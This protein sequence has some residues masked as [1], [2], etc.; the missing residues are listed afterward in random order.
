MVAD[1]A[2][3]R[4]KLAANAERFRTGMTKLGFTLAAPAIRSSR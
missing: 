1:G 2:D 4:R 3:L